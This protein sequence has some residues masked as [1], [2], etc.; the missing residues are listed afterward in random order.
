M[1]D[2]FD[3]YLGEDESFVAQHVSP[4]RRQSNSSNSLADPALL[5]ES[6]LLDRSPSPTPM[7][8]DHASGSPLSSSPTHTAI[9]QPSGSVLPPTQV[10]N[11]I[12][13]ID[14]Q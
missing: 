6:P 8:G 12:Y 1:N 9:Q 10:C 5:T 2:D 7:Q 14:I 3:G 13:K 11:T 4:Y